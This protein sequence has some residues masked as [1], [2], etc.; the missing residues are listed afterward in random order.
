MALDIHRPLQPL[1]RTPY[2]GTNGSLISYVQ[3][4][5]LLLLLLRVQK[6]ALCNCPQ[7]PAQLLC[8]QAQLEIKMPQEKL[9]PFPVKIMSPH[10]FLLPV[11]DTFEKGLELGGEE[12]QPKLLKVKSIS[13][14]PEGSAAEG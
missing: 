6:P 12:N 14:E 10:F 13:K 11:H 1:T 7:E 3:D 9:T 8:P 4:F 5:E 2:C